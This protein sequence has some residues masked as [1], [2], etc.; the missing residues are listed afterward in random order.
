[1]WQMC[2]DEEQEIEMLLEYY[3][4][5]SVMFVILLLDVYLKILLGICF[6]SWIH[7]DLESM[8]A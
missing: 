4:Q 5:R 1:M 7:R 6:I 2:A 3:L 8:V